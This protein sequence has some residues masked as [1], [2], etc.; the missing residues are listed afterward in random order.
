MTKV[1]AS[2]L[3]RITD[4]VLELAQERYPKAYGYQG[5]KIGR[6]HV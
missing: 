1:S 3:D 4:V 6:A 5:R 2:T